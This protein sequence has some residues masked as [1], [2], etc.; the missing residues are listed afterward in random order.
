MAGAA[1]LPLA[2]PGWDT[3]KRCQFSSRRRTLRGS[4]AIHGAARPRA[5]TGDTCGPLDPLLRH[6]LADAAG[7]KLRF[8]AIG[9]YIFG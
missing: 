3:F 9:T 2:H 8:G 1:L 5:I 6:Y 7:P 4:L